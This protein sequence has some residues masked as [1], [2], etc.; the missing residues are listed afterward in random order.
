[1]KSVYRGIAGWTLVCWV[2]LGV[3]PWCRAQ[4][5]ANERT[6]SQSKAVVEKAVKALASSSSGRL[7]VLDGFA[8]PGAHSLDHYQRGYYQC[9]VQ[10]VQ[11]SA[12]G[13]QV[14]VTAKIT[15]WYSD[16]TQSGYQVLPSNGRLESDFLDR[17][18]DALGSANASS[19]TAGKPSQNSS[20]SAASAGNVRSSSEPG[21]SKSSISA[22]APG[23]STL[24]DAIAASRTPMKSAEGIPAAPSSANGAAQRHDAEL[25]KEAAGLEEILRNQAHPNNLAAVKNA[26]TPVMTNPNEGA[27]VLFLADAEDEFE[28]LDSNAS[29][30]H[31]RIS[32]LSRGWILRTSVELPEDSD[33]GTPAPPAAVKKAAEVSNPASAA[34]FQVENEQIASFPGNWA[35]LRGKTVKIVSVQ[36]TS[37]AGAEAESKL[38]FAKGVFDQEYA[39]LSGASS[40][41]AGVVVIFDSEDG[42]MLAATLSVLKLWKSG[43]LSD[44]AMWRRCFFDPPEMA[45]SAVTR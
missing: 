24:A 17:L 6:F 12:G 30:V 38:A 37:P 41:T 16:G 4:S 11:N 20:S 35:P 36:R 27:K 31:V 2:C 43:S 34:P 42:G 18:Q 1:M 28:I 25:E 7:P 23:G 44:E 26:G 5:P 21:V 19:S 9:A 8:D 10:V 14:K 3:V 22:P 39:E 32:G 33:A 29:W 13:S 40:T 45:G 15:A